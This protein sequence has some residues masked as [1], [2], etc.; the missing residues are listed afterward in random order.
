MALP[1]QA[2]PRQDGAARMRSSIVRAILV[3]VGTAAL[4]LGIVGIVVPL[5]PTTPLLLLAAA[6]YARA[7]PRLYEWLIGQP[8]LG[9]I[10]AE[11]RRSRSLPPGVRTRALLTVAVVFAVSIVL[12]DALALRLGLTA[13]G[14]VLLFFLYRIPIARPGEG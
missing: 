1:D 4:L 3:V 14:V 8:A 11:W 9:P 12:V 2:S 6:S 13:V 10:V 5:L 7:S